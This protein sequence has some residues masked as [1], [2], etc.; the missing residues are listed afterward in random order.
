MSGFFG[1]ASKKDCVMDVFF[2][3]DYHSHLGTKR[4]GLVI[5]GE[6][7]FQRAIHNISSTPF[8]TKFTQD[9][10]E[11][12][13]NLGLGCISDSEPQPLMMRSHLGNFAIITVGRINNMD[14]LVDM[15][16]REGTTHFLEMSGGHINTTE[17]VAALIN[18]RSSIVDGIQYA[19][20]VIEGSMSILLMT[21]EGIYAARD[22][23][24]RTP[25]VIG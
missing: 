4:A 14:E 20:S 15:L 25:V 5:C 11:M 17:L 8:R 7:G 3:T 16:L 6:Q 19:Q 18:H 24:G 23:L 12:K 13:G 22:R 1:V 10:E 21:S 9:A 2:G